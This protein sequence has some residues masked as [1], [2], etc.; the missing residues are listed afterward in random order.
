MKVVQI[1]TV[2]DSDST[3]KI[4]AGISCLL[5]L[6][7]IDNYIIYTSGYSSLPQGIRCAEKFPKFQ[8]LRSRILG[9][10]GFNAKNATK[11]IITELSR[12]DP[13][14]VLL[15]NIHSHNVHLG[16][17]FAYLKAKQI[18]VLWTFHDCW[19]FTGYCPYFD[20]VEC[21]HWQTGCH[22][23]PQWT[24][25]SW[26]VDRSSDIYKKKKVLFTGLDLTIITPSRWLA[27]NVKRSF[28]KNY[29]V[30]V[31]HNGIDLDVFQPKAS[32]FREKYN[33][34]QNK[35]VLLG[36][37][38]KW[39]ARKG[40]DVFIKLAKELN[41]EIF[42]IVLVGTDS[43][44]DRELP[45]NVISIHRTENQNEL[46]EVYSSAD[47]F[48]NPT[49]EENFPTVNIEAIACGTPVLTYKTGGSSEMLDQKTGVVVER[50]DTVALLE[51]IERIQNEKPFLKEDCRNKALEFCYKKK[52][53]EYVQ[54]IQEFL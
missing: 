12:I 45:D 2:C 48:V 33:I 10:Y 27:D 35:F 50:N 29:P 51:A 43:N 6:S 20:M 30:R 1:N 5:N 49:M 34:A 7:G 23:C 9:N 32:C 3:G 17:L 26:F 28:L 47:L 42:Q 8:A 18:K 36:V 19:A 15:H 38:S 11:C 44:V 14:I 41:S 54:L 53:S 13:D 52:F 24:R 37:A 31:I 16:E 40:L 22:D 46:A 4:C 21:D 39:V 25:Y